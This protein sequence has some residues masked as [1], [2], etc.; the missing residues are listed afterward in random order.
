M[1]VASTWISWIISATPSI[2][3]SAESS[4]RPACISSATVLPSRAISAISLEMYAMAS[5]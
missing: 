5:G 3:S 2:T 1:K 4:F